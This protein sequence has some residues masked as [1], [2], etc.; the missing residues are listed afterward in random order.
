MIQPIRC[1][2]Q[3]HRLPIT[4]ESGYIITVIA[5]RSQ[6]TRFQ[7]SVHQLIKAVSETSLKRNDSSEAK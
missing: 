6:S 5:K 7:V 2:A 1:A 3:K 4:N